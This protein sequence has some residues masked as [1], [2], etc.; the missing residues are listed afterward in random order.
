MGSFLPSGYRSQPSANLAP[1]F[2]PGEPDAL[3]LPGAARTVLADFLAGGL[4]EARG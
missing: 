2:A 4:G 1:R 3:E